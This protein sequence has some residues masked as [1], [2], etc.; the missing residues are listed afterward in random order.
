MNIHVDD[1]TDIQ[2][3]ATAFPQHVT[4]PTHTQGH[5]LDL[6]ITHDNQTIS[7]HPVDPP[8]LSDHSFVVDDCD[9]LSPSM[10]ST[11]TRQVR[12]WRALDDDALQCSELVGSRLVVAAPPSDVE[13]AVNAY[14]T[15]LRALLDKHAPA[16]IGRVRTRVS[17]TR[18]KLEIGAALPPPANC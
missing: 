5:T 6:V 15:T 8:L 12:K 11:S 13:S 4:S 9:C 10:E 14:N 18:W 16:E 2:A 3:A 1:S 17:T 7:V